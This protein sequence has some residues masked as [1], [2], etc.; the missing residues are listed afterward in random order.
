[1]KLKIKVRPSSGLQ[2]I[3]KVSE[4]EYVV[5]LKNPASD[6]KANMELLNFL[7]REFKKNVRIIF[8]FNSRDKI[9]ELY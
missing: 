3:K 8:G 2:E 4:I 6:G 1:M 5:Y 7:K 9:I